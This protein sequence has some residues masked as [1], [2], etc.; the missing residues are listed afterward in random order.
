MFE[1]GDLIAAESSAAWL[2]CAQLQYQDRDFSCAFE[3]A[4][5]GLRWLMGVTTEAASSAQE[6][7]DN[8]V[9]TQLRLI[10]AGCLAEKGELDQARAA[11]SIIAGASSPRTLD[12]TKR[13]HRAL[14]VVEVRGRSH[15][16]NAVEKPTWKLTR[17]QRQALHGL[18]RLTAGAGNAEAAE[19]L[20]LRIL[21]RAAD[22]SAQR[23][24]RQEQAKASALAAFEHLL[25]GSGSEMAL[26]D[27]ARAEPALAEHGAHG[28][29]GWLLHQQGR[30]EV[31][32]CA[33]A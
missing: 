9:L 29:F 28:E 19:Q 18:A 21:G 11:F 2:V 12:I 31:L 13:Q 20:Y 3:T 7:K 22:L 6:R 17:S 16:G 5:A 25:G 1:L 8:D 24:A 23:L 32:S 27:G 26:E 14:L 30:N 10:V 15:A 33:C 4:T